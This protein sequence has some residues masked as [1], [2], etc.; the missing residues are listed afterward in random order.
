M[1]KLKLIKNKNNINIIHIDV[2]KLKYLLPVSDLPPL[3]INDIDDS[4]TET[5]EE[6][7]NNEES[8]ND[9]II[10]EKTETIVINKN[11]FFDELLEESEVNKIW[12]DILKSNKYYKFVSDKLQNDYDEDICPTKNLLFNA[13][14]LTNFPPKVVIL[15][16]DPYF[17]N[18]NEAMGLSF[19]VPNGIKLPPTLVNIFKEL[20]SDINTFNI[21]KS[22]DLTS[23]AKQGIL[24]LNTA[25][26]VIH[27]KKES[28]LS[29]WN[30]FTNELINKISTE[31]KQP[32]VFMLWG[33][34]A[35]KKSEFINNKNFHYILESAHPSPLGAIGGGW[36][37]CKHFS[38][39][40][41][42]LEKNNI[43]PINWNL[44]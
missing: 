20:N 16:Q 15:G 42:F 21:P 7:D 14:K 8:N 12:I 17:S 31:S 44:N 18:K 6:S 24:L 29:L 36:F 32:I 39:C 19:S 37:T 11:I 10:I 30:N 2:N 22:G 26:T 43:E 4:E 38:K 23:W 33:N 28:H 40:N 13:F 25:L 41:E 3:I 34:H 5:G 35:K 27:K 1:S 9:E